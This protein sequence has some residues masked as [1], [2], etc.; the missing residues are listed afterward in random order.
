MEKPSIEPAP[1]IVNWYT[2]HIYERRLNMGMLPVL[3]TEAAR[4]P[5][6]PNEAA[7]LIRSRGR[8]V[9]TGSKRRP[10]MNAVSCIN[11]AVRDGPTPAAAEG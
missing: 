8:L 9:V 2:H 5:I 4:R 3:R 11:I 7:P 1:L 10:E 6:A